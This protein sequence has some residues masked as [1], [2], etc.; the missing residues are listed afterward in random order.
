MTGGSKTGTGSRSRRAAENITFDSIDQRILDILQRDSEAPITAISE[1]VGLS[2]TPCWRRIKRMEEAGLIKGRV[3]LVDQKRANVP[4]TIF[5]G[6]TASRHEISW[7]NQFREL[8]EDIP[9][10]TEAYRLTGTVDYILKV[11]VPDVATYDRVYKQMI[12]RLEFN[13]I[14]SMISM[15]ELKFTTAIPTSYL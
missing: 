12:E 8:I 4:M 1:E 13:Q 11:V 7:L 9:E 15:E 5:I 10:I 2:A 6:V 3:A 14:N